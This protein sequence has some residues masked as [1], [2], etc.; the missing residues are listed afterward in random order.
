MKTLKFDRIHLILSKLFRL[1]SA[2][3]NFLVKGAE[4]HR[5]EQQPPYSDEHVSKFEEESMIVLPEEFRSFLTTA[6][7]SGPGPFQGLM[8][9]RDCDGHRTYPLL[10]FPYT[11]EAPFLLAE[12]LKIMEA[13]QKS[14]I[15][16]TEA[17]QLKTELLQAAIRKAL[18]G[19]IFLAS[20]GSGRY[21]ILIVNGQEFGHVWYLEL[22]NN[23]RAVPLYHPETGRPLTFLDWYEL[24]LDAALSFAD[25]KGEELA[26]CSTF[27]SNPRPE[28][29]Q[30]S[31][32]E[33]LTFRK[34]KFA[35]LIELFNGEID[36][37]SL[38]AAGKD[39]FRAV[40]SSI[41]IRLKILTGEM[42][43]GDTAEQALE[44][45]LLSGIILPRPEKHR[46]IYALLNYNYLAEALC[47]LYEK[48]F[49]DA[50][51]NTS[52][53]VQ[54][55]VLGYILNLAERYNYSRG[56]GISVAEAA[57]NAS[58][59]SN[60]PQFS[61]KVSKW[62]E[63]LILSKKNIKIGNIW[64]DYM[65]ILYNIQRLSDPA[66][67]LEAYERLKKAYHNALKCR[68]PFT[69]MTAAG[70]YARSLGNIVSSFSDKKT[71]FASIRELESLFVKNQS[72]PVA[73]TAC[74][75]QALAAAYSHASSLDP[76]TGRTRARYCA[77]I[78]E[79]W[80]KVRESE[81]SRGEESIAQYYVMA[82]TNWCR[83]LA[84]DKI[85]AQ[86][87]QVKDMLD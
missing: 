82:V 23:F 17:D 40:L 51:Q 16:Q 72:S 6:F 77:R 29:L 75:S 38:F 58:N 12:I 11:K 37:V 48:K 62:I 15:S 8:P 63:V 13:A 86:V 27:I 67:A 3:R 41:L 87:S 78:F 28:E 18:R 68:D 39:K 64:L 55:S 83:L 73:I 70:I 47:L 84:A 21:T 1:K 71:V 10:K 53:A 45:L 9:V 50:S 61:Y 2:D 32:E 35:S 44:A 14:P 74:T 4:V 60:D 54:E 57:M 5:Y 20:E 69:D 33:R 85:A 30:S 76:S 42:A 26:G 24:W 65:T 36:G 19:V 49:L 80:Q 34:K 7:S 22:E 25:G 52:A 56:H 81:S 46:H 66:N 43:L 31:L 59:S 79:I